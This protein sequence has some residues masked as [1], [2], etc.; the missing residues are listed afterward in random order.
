MVD[1]RKVVER[2]NSENFEWNVDGAGGVRHRLHR[3][4]RLVLRIHKPHTTTITSSTTIKKK[5]SNQ[6]K[7]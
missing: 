4:S 2:Y 1:D 6:S 5:C 7:R 3:T